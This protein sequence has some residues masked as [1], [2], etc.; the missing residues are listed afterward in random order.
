[1]KLILV[2]HGETLENIQGLLQ[3]HMPG[4]LSK[5]GVKQAKELALKLKAEK[6][7]CAYSSDLKRAVDTAKEVMAFH[8][9]AKLVLSKGLR[10]V[11]LGPFT[12]R[13]GCEVDWNNR[14]KEVETRQA[15]CNRVKP[16]LEDAFSKYPR[17]IVLFVGH[18]GTNL[19]IVSVLLNKPPSYMGECKAQENTGVDCFEIV[20][21]KNGLF[22]LG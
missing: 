14:P 7:D 5:K 22:S 8:P 21:Y 15:M 16:V 18:A 3:G 11:D 9:E 2:R 4:T 20:S 10:E 12:G 19:A 17:G 6:V 1:M 13:K